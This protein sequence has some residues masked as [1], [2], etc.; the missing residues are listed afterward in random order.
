MVD[1]AVDPNMKTLWVG[2]MPYWMDE[3]HVFATFASVGPVSSV[4]IVRNKA[5]GTSEGYGFIDFGTKEAADAALRTFNGQPVPNTDQFWR[6]NWSSPTLAG[7][8][9]RGG[10]DFSIFVGDL[11]PDV[12]DYV[13]QEHFRQYF[14]TVRSAKVI[15]DP[16][17]GRSKGYG[18][19]RFGSEAE[20]DRA[21]VDMQGQYLSSRPIRVSIATAKRNPVPGQATEQQ[22]EAR[23]ADYDP[24]NTT[25][26]IGG[27][28]ASVTEDQLR[29]IFGRFGDIVYTKIPQ[30]KGCGFVQYVDRKSAEIAMGEMNSCV[31]G[32]SA[33]RIS[34][35]R[36]S[37]KGG[38]RPPT[39]TSTTPQG[40]TSYGYQPA[41]GFSYDQ[42]YPPYISN[43]GSDPYAAYSAYGAP[44]GT[45]PSYAAYQPPYPP[46]APGAYGAPPAPRPSSAQGLASFVAQT[47]YDPLVP[48]DMD[49][50]NASY[51]YRQQPALL[52]SFLHEKAP[53]VH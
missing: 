7:G 9:T 52:G 40:S 25:L 49:R 35:G 38:D 20:R 21:L 41:S 45:D 31:I 15:T 44:A 26:F 42:S 3:N 10:E 6:L 37:G 24:S 2:D 19:V 47:L 11:A 4:K 30:G 18:F 53:L 16:I 29:S 36:S 17:T 43:Y 48:M 32:N 50:L 33:V 46:A 28:S 34:W 27:L 22:R 23:P 39:Q 51:I 1:P 13:L 14:P 8:Y 5:T 12:S